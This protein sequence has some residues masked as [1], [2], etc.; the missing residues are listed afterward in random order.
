MEYLIKD[1]TTKYIEGL[2]TSN[3]T[4]EEQEELAFLQNDAFDNDDE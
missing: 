3:Y 1:A 2:K 4:E